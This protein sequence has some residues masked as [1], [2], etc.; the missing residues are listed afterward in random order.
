VSAGTSWEQRQAD[1]LAAIAETVVVDGL[2]PGSG[3]NR[4][5][6]VVHATMADL[7]GDAGVDDPFVD[8]GPVVAGETVRRLMCDS[9]VMFALEG[10]DGAVV[11][12]SRRAATIPSALA[13]A[14]K[15]RDQGCVFPGCTRRAFVDIHHIHHRA[16][17]GENTMANC[18][19]L[20]RAHHR[21]VHVGGFT[22]ASES[23]RH[24]FRRPD[25][26]PITVGHTVVP[27][28]DGYIRDRNT[29]LGIRPTDETTVPDW[30]GIR[31]NYPMIIDLL[32]DLDGLR[33]D[34]PSNN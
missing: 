3:P 15:L 32:L 1:A 7:T 2:R 22:M 26:T 14:V 24:Q 20:C 13:R 11:N 33:D 12:V 31:P 34:P 5:T 10:P 17:Q 30:D 4:H 28:G 8:D 18:A 29:D 21:L 23:G 6:V 9:S 19:V 16:D 25:G 27:P